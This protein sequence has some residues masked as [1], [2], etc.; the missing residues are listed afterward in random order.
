MYTCSP[1]ATPSAP[2][3]NGRVESAVTV[4]SLPAAPKVRRI[5]AASAA[6]EPADIWSQPSSTR[7]DTRGDLVKAPLGLR[8]IASP[9]DVGCI[10]AYLL[11]DRER[12]VTR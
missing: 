8:C 12:Q 1:T 3:P 7:C 6:S 10:R 5:C 11:P 9:L 2:K 4:T